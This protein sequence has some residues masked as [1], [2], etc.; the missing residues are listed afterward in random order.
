MSQKQ[1]VVSPTSNNPSNHLETAPWIN[2]LTFCGLILA[3]VGAR[4]LCRDIPNFAP[5][6][7][8]ALFAGY[9]FT[10]RMLAIMV[11]I[12]VMLASD[13]ILGSYNPGLMA[14]VYG[15][16]ALPVMLRGLL[17][18]YL[19]FTAG[20]PKAIA[21]SSLG[22]VGCSVFASIAFFLVT[23]LAVW[24]QASWYTRDAAGLWQCYLQALPF[25]RYTLSGDLLFTVVLFGGYALATAKSTSPKPV[26]AERA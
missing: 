24:Y 22:I 18:Q 1:Q 17:R 3:G 4:L 5:V 23:N 14:V 2:G 13:C 12:L 25:F 10:S 20:R 7:A 26:S 21:Y 6:A 9:F 19:D 8:L 16:L 11:P 15:M